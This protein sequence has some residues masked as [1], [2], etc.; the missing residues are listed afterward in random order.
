MEKEKYLEELKFCLDHWE[1]QGG[2][3]FGGKTKC[4]ECAAPYLL[5]K[6]LSGKILHGD[7]KRLSLKDWK[8][9]I[10]EIE[11]QNETNNLNRN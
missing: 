1:K 10:K 11:T 5:L 9:K 2:C 8:N 6:L 4:E 7:M 3:S